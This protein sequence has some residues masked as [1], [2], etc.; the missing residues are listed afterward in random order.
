MLKLTPSTFEEFQ[1]ETQRGNVVP[2][3]RSVLADL[4][5]PVLAFLRI[6]KDAP[7]AF[8]LESIEGGERVARYSFLAANP[9]MIARAQG[10]RTVVIQNGKRK[11]VKQTGIEFLRKYFAD[12]KLVRRRGLAPFAGGAVGYL[13]YSAARWFEPIL[14]ANGAGSPGDDAVWMFFKTVIAFDR[15][16]QQ[17]EITSIV[18]TDEAAGDEH[19]LRD[20]YDQAIAETARIEAELNSGAPIR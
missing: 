8:L 7:H 1:A 12:K 5:T 11:V 15:V 6:A 10:E 16:R 17:M 14:G 9:W 18:F 2:V 20:L 19:G 4:Q 3:V 13:A